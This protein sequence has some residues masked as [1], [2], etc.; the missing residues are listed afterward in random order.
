MIHRLFIFA[1]LIL[2]KKAEYVAQARMD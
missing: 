1:I 2:A